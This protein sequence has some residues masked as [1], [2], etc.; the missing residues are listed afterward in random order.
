[1]ARMTSRFALFAA[2]AAALSLAATPAEAR[3]WG[4]YHHYRGNGIS[5][6]DVIA[7][8][9]VIGGI[10][11][12]ASAASKSKHDSER[13]DYPPP[14]PPAPRYQDSYDYAP[15][16]RDYQA[17]G[18]ND[19]VNM[20]VG[21]VERGNDRVAS[22]DNASRSADGWRVAGRLSAGGGFNCWIDNDGRVRQVDFGGDRYSAYDD[23]APAPDGQWSDD[24]YARAR[25]QA[26]A[27][28]D[29]SVDSDLA[30]SAE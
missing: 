23:E 26:D 22:V 18:I 12:I 8:A 10:A 2:A 28:P 30:Y 15:P 11:A 9:L 21:Q 29:D 20:C 24:D 7:G 3:G 27:A 19:A 16:A 4:H 1:M 6:G 17:G 5:A 13:Y 14:P 25:E